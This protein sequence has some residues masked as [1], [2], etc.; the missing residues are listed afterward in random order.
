MVS[1]KIL[2][3]SA[4]AY[5]WKSGYC[6]MWLT[7]YDW[8]SQSTSAGPY[9]TSVYKRKVALSFIIFKSRANRKR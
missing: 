3:V 8:L 2:T 6:V 4:P 5:L 9:Q 1:Y 7:G